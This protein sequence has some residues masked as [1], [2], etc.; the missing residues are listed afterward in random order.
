MV[1]FPS[2][3]TDDNHMMMMMQAQAGTSTIVILIL[4]VIVLMSVE[5]LSACGC[6]LQSSIISVDCDY[7]ADTNLCN[8]PLMAFSLTFTLETEFLSKQTPDVVD[9]GPT[10][11]LTNIDLTS[12][13]CWVGLLHLG[14]S[15]GLL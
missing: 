9:S 11:K 5:E 14:Y 2:L 8:S 3:L 13:V 12:C 7:R 10:L 4:I 1:V 15:I 6:R